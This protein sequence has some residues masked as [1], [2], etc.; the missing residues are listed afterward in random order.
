MRVYLSDDITTKTEILN[1]LIPYL[2]LN[3]NI[4]VGTQKNRLNERS[5][6][7]RVHTVCC[8]DVFNVLAD[9]TADKI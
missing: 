6:H 5:S 2:C 8:R 4:V 1:T 9:D 3:Q 7:I